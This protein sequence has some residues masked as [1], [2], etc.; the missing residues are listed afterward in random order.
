MHPFSTFFLL[1]SFTL[2]KRSIT[3]SRK[4]GI[5]LENGCFYVRCK[6]SEVFPKMLEELFLVLGWLLKIALKCVF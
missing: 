5:K 1:V 3:F 6:Y 4:P 2:P